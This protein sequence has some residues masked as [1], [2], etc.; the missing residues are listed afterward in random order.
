[1]TWT[2]PEPGTESS[3]EW[4][5]LARRI[6]FLPVADGLALAEYRAP[7]NPGELAAL[8]DPAAKVASLRAR[9]PEHWS[10]RLLVSMAIPQGVP[11]DVVRSIFAAG[12]YVIE[13]P[14][15][16]WSADELWR[17]RIYRGIVPAC[18]PPKR[19]MRLASERQ[20]HEFVPGAYSGP[21]PDLSPED[22]EAWRRRVQGG[23]EG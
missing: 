14:D 11:G 7:A 23:G 17:I 2:A 8:P 10:G 1:M 12:A 18:P 15:A 4:V 6:G 16:F 19:S 5:A 9:V 22:V 21:N 13:V 20:R 3:R